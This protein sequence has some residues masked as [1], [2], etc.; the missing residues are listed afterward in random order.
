VVVS[1]IN[2]YLGYT[3]EDFWQVGVAGRGEGKIQNSTGMCSYRAN[4]GFYW[5]E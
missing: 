5:K 1:L 2:I 4:I 3:T